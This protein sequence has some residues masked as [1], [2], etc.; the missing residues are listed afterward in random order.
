VSAVAA[1]PDGR[2][3]AF[4]TDKPSIAANSYRLAWH[5]VDLATG[6][7]REIASAGDPIVK[8]PGLLT[9]EAPVWSPDGRWIYYR[10][11]HAGEVQIWRTA[12]DGSRSEAVTA[13][14]GDVVAVEAAADGRGIAFRVG[15]PRG[16]IEQAELAEYDNGILVDEH[17]ELA[18]NLFRGAIVNGRHAT[19]RLNGPWFF[20]GNVLW[21]RPLLE[22]RLDF[23]SLAA[24]P[25]TAA[26]FPPS[27]P[28]E[29]GRGPD[30]FARS[31]RGDVAAAWWNWS[32]GR[33]AVV[34][35]DGT[36]IPC[37]AEQCRSER[38]AW[39]AWRPGMD[40]VVFA[41]SNRMR[42]QTIRLWNPASGKVRALP[43]GSGQLSGG[44]DE[45]APCAILAAQAVCVAAGPAS[46]PRLEAIDLG[47]GEAR[48]LFDLEPSL[49]ARR[50]PRTERLTWRSPAGQTFTG[51]LFL[52]DDGPAA[53]RP[54]PLFVNYYSCGGFVRGG[55][56]DEW[57]FALL[58]ANGIASVCVNATRSDAPNGVG[59]Y[60]AA[61]GGL[62]TLVDGLARRGVADRG[63][64]G[65]GGLSFGTEVTIW[66]LIHSK[67]LA[68]AS[69][70]SPQFEA[71]SYWIN[72]ARGREYPR[73]LREVWG[74]GPP[75]QTPEQW[76]LLSAARNI[77]EIRAPLLLQLSEQESRYATELYAR[78]S[79]SATPTEMYVFPDEAH[80]K[81]QPRHRLAVYG[82]NLDWFG[83]WLQDRVDPEPAKA[84]QYRRWRA[85]RDRSVAPQARQ[86]SSHSAS[87]TKSNNR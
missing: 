64:V 80:I 38:T 41:T 20:R 77:G 76:Q 25:A 63:R 43:A 83:F 60:R 82:R 8:E 62:E 27:P 26:D 55:V 35:A 42:V 1:S 50:W 4:R 75:D 52:P 7:S 34:R 40:E 44:P 10:A 56:G 53:R 31:S 23:A 39:I 87:E 65:M 67:L 12:T 29:G 18:Q 11:L 47:S 54:V 14:A 86:D 68:A 37:P 15:P 85:L 59:A 28:A 72:S 6:A 84:E 21:S 24:T 22:R 2:L 69:I 17:V 30:V 5:V 33:L 48:P 36:R 78:L 71:S 13:E 51:I 81:V 73:I 66:T 16:E 19:Q 57:P 49:R 79:N 46:P 3:V 9:A 32:E 45:A 61:L 74:L 70:A 58:A